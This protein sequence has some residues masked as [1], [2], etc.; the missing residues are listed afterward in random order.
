MERVLEA[1]FIPNRSDTKTNKKESET[2][3]GF[4]KKLGAIFTMQNTHTHTHTHTT[5]RDITKML[6]IKL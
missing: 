3:T 5:G 4:L 2:E 6:I 1:V